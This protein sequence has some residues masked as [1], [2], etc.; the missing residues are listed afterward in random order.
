ML[1]NGTSLWNVFD[2][3]SFSPA[4]AA[5]A[6]RGRTGLPPPRGRYTTSSPAKPRS[7]IAYLESK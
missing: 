4:A 5:A 3:I 6:P 7:V 2:E 1:C